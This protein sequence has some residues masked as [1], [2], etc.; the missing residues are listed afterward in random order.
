[1][2]ISEIES[3]KVCDIVLNECD[4]DKKLWNIN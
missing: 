2:K 4:N 1:M 3:I